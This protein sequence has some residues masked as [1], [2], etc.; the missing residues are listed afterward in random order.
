M[1]LLLLFVYLF[2][3]MKMSTTKKKNKQT[4]NNIKILFL[5]YGISEFFLGV[6]LS[7]QYR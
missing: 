5:Q 4:M 1:L 6:S 2:E 3:K 7:Q